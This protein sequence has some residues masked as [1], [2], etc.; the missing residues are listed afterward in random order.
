MPETSTESAVELRF[1]QINRYMT[2]GLLSILVL[3]VIFSLYLANA[4]QNETIANQNQQLQ[5]QAAIDSDI[6]QVYPSQSLCVIAREIAEDPSNPVEDRQLPNGKDGKDGKDGTP[7]RGVS[8]FSTNVSGD[9]IVTYSD[10]RTQNAGR[11]LGPKGETGAEGLPGKDGRGIISSEVI[12]GALIIRYSDGTSQNMGVVVGPAGAN[13]ANGSDGSPGAN[14]IDGKEGPPGKDGKDGIDGTNGTDGVSVTRVY[15]RAS[16]NMVI[17]E[18]SNGVSNEVGTII[19]TT[20]Q[21]VSCTA[22]TL[23][24]TMTDG[25]SASAGVHCSD[26]PEP[27]TPPQPSTPPT[28]IPQP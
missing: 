10:G 24:V 23:T 13:G 15:T 12:D 27:Y 16:D 22:G 4:K 18:L 20:I 11:V 26:D 5:A 14:G 21:S 3:G 2:I 19:S 17:V 7:G 25:R 1:K 9:L 6:C 28:T 8:S